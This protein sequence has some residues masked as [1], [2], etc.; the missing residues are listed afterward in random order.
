VFPSMKN[1]E[2]VGRLVVV[3]DANPIHLLW[4]PQV[5]QGIWMKD[6]THADKTP[7]DG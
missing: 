1:G 4:N 6:S 5:D 2:S 3:I 7:M